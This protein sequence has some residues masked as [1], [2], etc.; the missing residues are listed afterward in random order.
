M[1]AGKYVVAVFV[2]GDSCLSHR[3]SQSVHVHLLEDV[4]SEGPRDDFFFFLELFG[5]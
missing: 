5:C 3:A 1:S 4:V 2:L